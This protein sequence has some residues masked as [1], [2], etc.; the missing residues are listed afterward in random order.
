MGYITAKN[1]KLYKDGEEILLRGFGLGGWLLPEGYMWKL[2]TKCDRPRRMEAMIAT[3]C[4]PEYEQQFWK[5]YYDSYITYSDIKLIAEEGFNSVRLPLNARHLFIVKNGEVSF[6]ENMLWYID[7]CI[8]WCKEKGIYVILD[9]HGAFGGQTGQNID[10]SE[11]D[12]PRLFM[13][14][15]NQELLIQGWE[16]LATRYNK[17]TTVAGYDLLNEPL[18]NFF[19]QY[20]S[21]LLPLYRKLITA[22]R[23]KDKNHLIILE[24]LHWATDFSIFDEFTKEEAS[25]NIMLQFHKYWN[26]PDV[27]SIEHFIKVAKRLEVPLFMGEGGENNCNWYTT[28]FPMFER[29]KISWSFWSYKKMD[30]TNSPV[31]FSTPKNWDW[32]I[33]W[34]DKE[35]QLSRQEAITIFDSFIK[36]VQT[37]RVNQA[38]FNALKRMVPLTIPCESYDFYDVQSDRQYGSSFRIS[39]PV[40]I[41]FA[42]GKQGEANYKQYGGEKQPESETLVVQLCKGDMVGYHFYTNKSQ[43]KAC[44]K[45]GGSGNLEIRCGNNKRSIYSNKEKTI[46]VIL[47]SNNEGLNEISIRCTMGMILIN[48]ITLSEI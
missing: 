23:K 46:E 8:Q 20:N 9:M 13:D 10:D 44:I 31:T 19:S 12:Q 45:L 24:G 34:I 43:I 14:K 18:P 17:E 33:Q 37:S 21:M 29:E 28:A 1:S 2:Y 16:L 11:D 3:L 6:Q 4:G 39:D 48:D 40:T 47:D 26:P 7:K 41:L 25:N 35:R 22:I 36:E 15:T 30:C 38:V 27:E 32:I 5:K 42:N